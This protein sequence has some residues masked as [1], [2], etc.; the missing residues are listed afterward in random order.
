MAVVVVV[1]TA[2]VAAMVVASR[3]QREAIGMKRKGQSE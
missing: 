1:A 3:E 2:T